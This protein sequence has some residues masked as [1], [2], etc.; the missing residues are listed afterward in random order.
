MLALAA[1]VV[2]RSATGIEDFVTLPES[3]AG[4]GGAS[5]TRLSVRDAPDCTCLGASGGAVQS[6]IPD[7]Y[8]T[9]NICAIT[10]LNFK[11]PRQTLNFNFFY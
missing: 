11:E 9:E 1:E 7:L 8:A 5:R 3:A 2:F 6:V 4:W 10:N